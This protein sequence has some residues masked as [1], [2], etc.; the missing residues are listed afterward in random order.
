MT[1]QIST[2]VSALVQGNLEETEQV[3]LAL[4]DSRQAIVALPA[5]TTGLLNTLPRPFNEDRYMLVPIVF[6]G[7][8]EST[9]KAIVSRLPIRLGDIP[10]EQNINEARKILA[11]IDPRLRMTV[12]LDPNKR[13]VIVTIAGPGDAPLPPPK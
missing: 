3:V 2:A 5:V 11:D 12:T 6:E 10:T 4:A 9:S 1:P 7:V 13:H 8:S